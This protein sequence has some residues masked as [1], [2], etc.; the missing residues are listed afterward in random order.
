MAITLTGTGGLFT[1]LGKLGKLLYQSHGQ[2]ST[3]N[4]TIEEVRAQN[5]GEPDLVSSLMNNSTGVRS[6]E[7]LNSVVTAQ[8]KATMLR[9]VYRDV[10]SQSRDLSTAIAE[11]IRQMQASSDSV[12]AC[13]V[14]TTGTADS[15]NYGNGPIVT[16]TKLANGKTAENI[17]AETVRL[18]ASSA[19][20]FSAQG[21]S[22]GTDRSWYEWPQGSSAT[23]SVPVIDA[24]G[25]N[26]LLANSNFE[27]FTSNTPNKWTGE[28]GVAGTH[29]LASST[30]YGDSYSLQIAG[31]G[32]NLTSLYQKF[33]DST[34]G[35]SSILS[36]LTQYAFALKAKVSS[37]P[38]AGV[39]TIELIGG[40][41]ESSLSVLTDAEGASCSTTKSLPDLTT[42][43][44]TISGV[45]RT[46][47]VMPTYVRLRLRLSTALSNA[48]NLFLDHLAFGAMTPLYA[49]GPSAAVFA[50]ATDW[51][52]GDFFAVASTNNRG[53]ASYLATFQ[54]LFDRLFDMRSLG[55]VLPS[56]ASP[57]LADTLITA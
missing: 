55:L 34:N 11:L 38:G 41:S 29:F 8:A 53:G 23:A 42:S 31:D 52:A 33:N 7:A 39:L 20:Q 15:G 14:A 19:T 9:M 45:F 47:K 16:S 24:D 44:S 2:Q 10:P 37:V 13:T 54:A 22:V 1:R 4:T 32:S 48:V 26:N 43:W 30:A 25:T 51:A 27:S 40:E 28:V 5:E 21:P 35:T 18:T 49:G 50:G 36:A 6:V 12:K 57:T 3:I 17:V 46:P 56:D